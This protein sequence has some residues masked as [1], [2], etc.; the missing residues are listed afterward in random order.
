[1]IFNIV[2]FK[3]LEELWDDLITTSK[4]PVLDLADF[5]AA[6][7]KFHSETQEMLGGS[8][9]PVPEEDPID[10]LIRDAREDDLSLDFEQLLEEDDVPEWD[11]VPS[12]PNADIP[13]STNN[14][15]QSFTQVG[16]L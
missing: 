2:T 13:I 7:L 5:A 8:V 10:A 4:V 6:T 3:P 16:F 9:K 12:S 14:H 11:D 1:M 15:H